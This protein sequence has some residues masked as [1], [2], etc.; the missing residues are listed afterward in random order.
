MICGDLDGSIDQLYTRVRKLKAKKQSFDVLFCVGN[1]FGDDLKHWE[2][3]RNGTKTAPIQTY[4]LGPNDPKHSD[5]YDVGSVDGF[6]FC[7]NITYLGNRGILTTKDGLRV[8]YISG[9]QSPSGAKPSPKHCFTDADTDFVSSLLKSNHSDYKGVDILLTSQWPKGI[10]INGNTPSDSKCT[11][12]GSYLLSKFVDQIKPRYHF[13]GLEGVFY[14]RAPYRNHQVL[15]EQARHVTRF[16]ALA[17]MGNKNRQRYLYA[18]TITP[19][20]CLTHA[21]LVRQPEDVTETPFKKLIAHEEAKSIPVITSDQY[22]WGPQQNRGQK[23][24]LNAKTHNNGGV[25]KKQARPQ[26]WSCWFCLGGDKVEKHLVASVG[27]LTYVAA[28]KGQLVPGHMLICPVAHHASTMDLPDDTAEEVKKFKKAMSDAFASTDQHCVIFER[29]YKSDH[30]Q[31]Q[32]VPVPMAITADAIKESIVNCALSQMDRMGRR[33]PIDFAELPSR[34]DLKQVVK[35]GV[36]F[37]HIELPDGQRLFHKIKGYFP[38]QFGR[39]SLAVP[40]VLNLPKRVDWREC[41]QSRSEEEKSTQKF[42]E[43]FKQF[44]FTNVEDSDSS[45]SD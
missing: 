20:K 22:R 36:P 31:I 5:Y 13:V 42:R 14:E 10:A 9:I 45:D 4:I 30:L 32:V 41:T 39:E 2:L 34:T 35:D 27:K 37:F 15:Q 7:K 11:S 25:E 44:D 21:E 40:T 8:A 19:I 29:N 3:Y 18:F 38:L 17:K 6:E 33:V 1:F 23:R 24:K 12:C 28:A 16:L 26:D 43:F